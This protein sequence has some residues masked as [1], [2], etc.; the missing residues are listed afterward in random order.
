MS[1][2]IVAPPGG[3]AR[4]LAAIVADEASDPI[5]TADGDVWM[6]AAVRAGDMT[7]GD[8]DASL[9][10][11]RCWVEARRNRVAT[12]GNHRQPQEEEASCTC[13]GRGFK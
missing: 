12:G 9:C 2:T 5:E 4:N 11:Q 10:Q 8:S 7:G 3:D 6:V 1:P 13:A